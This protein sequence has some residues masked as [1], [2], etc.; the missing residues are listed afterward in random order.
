MIRKTTAMKHGRC[1]EGNAA[2]GNLSCSR[3]MSVE[4]RGPRAVFSRAVYRASPPAAI[5]S[6]SLANTVR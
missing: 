6:A 5:V 1:F 3:R 2:R 4:L